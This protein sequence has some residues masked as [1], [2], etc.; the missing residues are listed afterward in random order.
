MWSPLLFGLLASHAAAMRFA[1]YID[2]YVYYKWKDR[3]RIHPCAIA[4][5][6]RILIMLLLS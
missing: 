3:D 5:Q 4:M 6:N 1:M 2:P